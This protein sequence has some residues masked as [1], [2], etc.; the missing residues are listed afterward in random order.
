[1]W[2][3]FGPSRRLKGKSYQSSKINGMKKLRLVLTVMLLPIGLALAQTPMKESIRIPL[4]QVP[5]AVRQAFEKDFGVIPQ[6]GYWSAYIEKTSGNRGTTAKP[7]WYSYNKR[8]RSEKIEV[9]FL[10]SGE[11]TLA[12][13]VNKKDSTETAG[14]GEPGHT[15]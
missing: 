2:L 11:L 15:N 7:L 9:R 3:T 10:P 13:G 6:D 14:Q 1:V 12:K 5:A 4:D 8:N